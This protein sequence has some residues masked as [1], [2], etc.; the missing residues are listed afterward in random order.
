MA[1]T[2]KT[3]E[4][5]GDILVEGGYTGDEFI[6][7]RT[8]IGKAKLLVNGSTAVLM[9]RDIRKPNPK[10]EFA[11]GSKRFAP[12]DR[13]QNATVEEGPK[14]GQYVVSGISDQLVEQGVTGAD[15]VVKWTFLR[16]RCE[17]C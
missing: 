16:V 7:D 12:F 9:Q 11:Q 10:D 5:F 17:S 8:T 3:P 14:R 6:T 2:L 15:A 1:T 4:L 13:I